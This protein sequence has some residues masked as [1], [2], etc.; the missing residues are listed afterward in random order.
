MMFDGFDE[1]SSARTDKLHVNY[2]HSDYLSSHTVTL[3]RQ[4]PSCL[5]T[6]VFPSSDHPIQSYPMVHYLQ[7][8]FYKLKKNLQHVFGPLVHQFA[9]EKK[10]GFRKLVFH[11]IF[12]IELW[13]N[14][15]L[16]QITLYE[17]EQYL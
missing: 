2:A 6:E 14:K 11:H 16:K 1:F 12:L 10:V 17:C 8:Q 15:N 13:N 4:D 3:P 9:S 7:W 5:M